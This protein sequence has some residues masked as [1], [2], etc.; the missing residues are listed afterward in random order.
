[1][2]LK[3]E[4]KAQFLHAGLFQRGEYSEETSRRKSTRRSKKVIDEQYL[5]ALTILKETVTPLK[6]R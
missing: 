5:V 2:Y 6:R 1:V 3:G 4:P